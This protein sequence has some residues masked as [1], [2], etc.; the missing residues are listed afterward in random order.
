MERAALMEANVV[1]QHPT[2]Q[3]HSV[4]VEGEEPYIRQLG[5]SL[6]TLLPL[7]ERLGLTIALENMLPSGG[8]RFASRPEHL[9]KIGELFPHDR[10]GFCLDT[11]H[12]L[13]AGGP[14]HAFDF[15][16]T[17]KDRMVAFHLA[18][19][20]GDRDSHLAPGRGMVDWTR[21]FKGVAHAGYTGTLCIE[22]PPFGPGPPYSDADW[23][24]LLADA[25]RLAENALTS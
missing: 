21:L 14:E 17:M 9:A 3:R 8:G 24:A 25:R 5:R 18:D 19:N 20:A 1:I 15:F 7:A 6:E 23:A 2:T 12:A 10:L 13:V 11:G 22:T 4:D 16:E